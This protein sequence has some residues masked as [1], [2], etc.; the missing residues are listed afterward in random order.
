MAQYCA[1]RTR[2]GLV[3]IRFRDR[4]IQPALPIQI[5]VYRSFHTWRRWLQVSQSYVRP[6]DGERPTPNLTLDMATQVSAPQIKVPHGQN[7]PAHPTHKNLRGR[8]RRSV[9]PLQSATTFRSRASPLPSTYRGSPRVDLILC[10]RRQVDSARSLHSR[11]LSSL[12]Q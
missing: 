5:L 7:G 2:Q 1:A 8:Q 9:I 3:W 11:W 12:P 4:L 6:L 10:H